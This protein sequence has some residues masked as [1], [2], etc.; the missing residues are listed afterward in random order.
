M[1]TVI[2]ALVDPRNHEVRYV[3]K[4]R[5]FQKRIR[6]HKERMDETRRGIWVKELR[7]D[8][9]ALFPVKL[10][11]V[12]D[13]HADAAEQFWISQGRL[14]GWALTNTVYNNHKPSR[15]M[16]QEPVAALLDTPDDAPTEAIVEREAEQVPPASNLPLLTVQARS[17]GLE[18]TPQEWDALARLD[19]GQTPYAV[20]AN[21]AGSKSGRRWS[22]RRNELRHLVNFVRSSADSVAM[23]VIADAQGFPLSAGRPLTDQE[24]GFVRDLRSKGVSLNQIVR[25]VYGHKDGKTWR[26]IQE[27]LGV[28]V[29]SEAS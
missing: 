3:G 13:M 19:R 25:T 7:E 20:A 18:L 11:E 10:A 29:E 4:T 6:A 24:A 27:A 23:Q 21:W 16:A 22:S 26:Y 14:F 1:T 2:Y 17:A 8:G 28:T 5:H 9:R 15:E 12:D